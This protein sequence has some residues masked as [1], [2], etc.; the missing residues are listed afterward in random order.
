[1][2]SIFY[3]RAYSQ[4]QVIHISQHKGGQH[5]KKQTAKLLPYPAPKL[6]TEHF[7]DE[8]NKSRNGENPKGSGRE[9]E[10]PRTMHV[11]WSLCLFKS[12]TR[13]LSYYYLLQKGVV[14]ISGREITAFLELQFYSI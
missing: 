8:T 7:K 4:S 9:E 11:V 12:C 6:E 2:P 5:F 10:N 14:K 13:K 3:H 1:M